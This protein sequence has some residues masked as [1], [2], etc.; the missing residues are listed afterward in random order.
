MAGPINWLS[1]VVSVTGFGV[2]SIPQRRGSVAAAVIGIA[3]VVA[4]LVGVLSIGAGFK[5]VMEMSASPDSAMV[6]RASATSE[7][8]SGLSREDTKLITDAP[9]IARNA[10]GPLA[11]AELFVIIDL[12]KR[13][14]NSSANVPLRGIEPAGFAVR[15]N[16]KI[17]E[18]RKFEWGKNEIVV[19]VGALQSL[20]DWN[21]VKPCVWAVTTGPWWVSSQ[22][23][24]ARRIPNSGRMPRFCRPPTSVVT[25]FNP[26]L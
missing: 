10:E 15:D 21:L 20:Q 3:G 7:M 11:S 19:G 26:C 18:G 14:T 22:P 12:P 13:S 8:V 2:L 17:V 9:G 4:V 23:A 6:L 1:Q 24:A 5:R 16:L 25:V